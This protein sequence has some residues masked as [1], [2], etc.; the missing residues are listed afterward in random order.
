MTRAAARV[1]G[2]VKNKIK[3]HQRN[4]LQIVPIPNRSNLFHLRNRS[5]NRS[6]LSLLQI[7]LQ[8]PKSSS[9]NRTFRCLVRRVKVISY[10]SPASGV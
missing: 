1:Q 5:L 6:N 10:S 3:T 2:L 8:I 7:T 9:P 4:P